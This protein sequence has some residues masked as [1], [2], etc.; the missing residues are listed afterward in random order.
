[1]RKTPW[2]AALAAGVLL[3]APVACGDDWP[4]LQHDAARSGFSPENVGLPPAGDAQIVWRWHPDR[5]TSVAGR[6]QPV[7]RNGLLCVGFLDGRMFG[8]DAATGQTRW[9]FQAGGAIHHTAAI[10]AQH[11]YFGS[12]DGRVYALRVGDG[13]LAW[14]VNTGRAVHNAPCL[15]EN[16]VFIGNSRGRFLAIN[17][18][19]GTVAWTYEAGRP[20][21]IS[22]AYAN[23][24]V[25]C[26]DEGLYAFALNAADGSLLWRVRLRGQSMFG[27]WPVVMPS[28]NT[29]FYRTQAAFGFHDMLNDGDDLLGGGNPVEQDGTPAQ[30]AAERQAIRNYL[31]ANPDR[32]TFWALNTADGSQRYVAPVLMTA[33]GN[34]TPVPP[35]YDPATGRAWL[36][37]RSRYARWDSIS[38]V[39]AYG[40]EPMRFDPLT[41]DTTL[42]STHATRG[43]GVHMIGDETSLLTADNYGLLV[44]GRGTLGYIRHS[45]ETAQH[46]VSSVPTAIDDYAHPDSPLAY[47]TPQFPYFSINAGGGAG[48]GVIAGAAV[49]DNAL[50]WFARYGL[51]VRVERD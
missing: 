13:S 26:G 20:I 3:L 38:F 8:L 31:T 34:T 15:A 40:C 39:R 17:A 43:S 9:V 12:Q 10:D 5:V 6:V 1:M 49:A 41:G 30:H 24:R 45:P 36:I 7:V 29:V 27:Y 44:S 18:A 2:V 21:E 33:G 4:Q 32:Q 46:I 25:Y 51:L 42:L 47:G 50:F 23:G 22:A 19:D 16:R 11:V 37:G 48:G 35:I 28:T 14:V